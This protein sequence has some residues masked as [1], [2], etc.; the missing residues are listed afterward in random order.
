MQF[1]YNCHTL[2]VGQ[3]IPPIIAINVNAMRNPPSWIFLSIELRISYHCV[4]PSCHNATCCL[5]LEL[6]WLCMWVNK[7]GHLHTAWL[8]GL[9]D[10]ILLGYVSTH[11]ITQC[12]F[13][14]DPMVHY[15]GATMTRDGVYALVNENNLFWVSVI[16]ESFRHRFIM[17]HYT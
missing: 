1:H 13:I 11:K 15:S 17:L 16:W 14:I 9:V 12:L 5:A 10:T 7:A 8:H 2:W 3:V 6:P 4:F